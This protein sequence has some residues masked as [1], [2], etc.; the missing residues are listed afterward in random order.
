MSDF[1]TVSFDFLNCMGLHVWLSKAIMT[2][3]RRLQKLKDCYV[4]KALVVD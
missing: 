2:L 3:Q 1:Y 4:G